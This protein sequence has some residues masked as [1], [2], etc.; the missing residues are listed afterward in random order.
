M[1]WLR[2]AGWGMLIS[3]LG[4]LPLGTLN[5]AAL[6]IAISEG[7]RPALHFTLGVV[8]VEMIYVRVSVVAIAWVRKHIAWLQYFD[9]AALLILVVLAAGSFYA[10]L[11]PVAG[12]SFVLQMLLP[13]WVLGVIMSA[14]NPIQIPFW[15]GWTTVLF[16]KKVLLARQDHYNAYVIGI[17]LGTLLVF[18][19]FIAGGPWLVVRLNASQAMVNY[20]MGVVFCFAALIQAVRMKRHKPARFQLADKAAKLQTAVRKSP[21]HPP[22][23]PL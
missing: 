15:F 1:K 5:M 3:A 11:H 2:V 17:G 19:I 16:N 13:F 10:A 7:W 8:M 20:M 18:N 9:Y 12:K 14:L 6:Q 21:D 22:E 23:K 4:A